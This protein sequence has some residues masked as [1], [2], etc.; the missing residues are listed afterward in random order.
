MAA[1]TVSMK[2]LFRRLGADDPTATYIVDQESLNRLSVLSKMDKQE[3]DAKDGKEDRSAIQEES[4]KDDRD[5][6]STTPKTSPSMAWKTK[7]QRCPT[8]LG[9]YLRQGTGSLHT[10]FAEVNSSDES[11]RVSA[12]TIAENEF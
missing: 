9:D 11:T 4:K 8:A 10:S 12:R 1:Q 7:R 2:A 6:G 5:K 3:V